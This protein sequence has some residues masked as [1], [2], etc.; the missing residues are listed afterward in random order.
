[1]GW[2]EYLKVKGMDYVG[3]QKVGA[4]GSDA[5]QEAFEDEYPAPCVVASFAVR[6]ADCTGEEVSE[7]GCKLC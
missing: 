2:C 6:L 7:C 5:G 4:K 1:M 3:D